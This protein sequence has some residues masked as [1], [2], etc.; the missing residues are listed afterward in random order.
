MNDQ[1]NEK[2][3]PAITL[4]CDVATQHFEI[5]QEHN[6]ALMAIQE[7]FRDRGDAAFVKEYQ[8]KILHLRH[9]AFA[10]QLAQDIAVF[11]Q[12]IQQIKSLLSQ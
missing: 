9:G 12:R 2:L 8:E 4:L 10:Q 3:V 6:L 11:R 5:T 7:V 1:E